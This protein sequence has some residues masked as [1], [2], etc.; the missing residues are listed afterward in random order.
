MGRSRMHED[1][2]T[3]KAFKAQT[4]GTRKKGRPNLRWIDGLE[5][6]LLVSRTKNWRTLAGRR[7]AWKRIL[8]KAK[9][10]LGLF[11]H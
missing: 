3:K 10:H 6:D 4:I 2:T 7:L 11:S 9:A 1:L 5:K 8:E